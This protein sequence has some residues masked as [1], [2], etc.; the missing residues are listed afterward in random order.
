MKQKPTSLRKSVRRK[1]AEQIKKDRQQINAQGREKN[2]ELA[3]SLR[4]P[5]ETITLPGGEV[6]NV[7]E[8][9]YL[10]K[11]KVRGNLHIFGVVGKEGDR[12]AS[13]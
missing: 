8:W 10:R 4:K 6:R 9:S 3:V 1:V 5:R 11:A 13:I 7:M 2:R 12:N